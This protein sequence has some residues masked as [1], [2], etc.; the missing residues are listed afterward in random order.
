MLE[1]ECRLDFD[2]KTLPSAEVYGALG[3]TGAAAALLGV[4]GA[5]GA[6]GT[7]HAVSGTTVTP[8]LFGYITA[9]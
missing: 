8:M 1:S 9:P 2:S 6:A 3:D 4:A 5:L 7:V